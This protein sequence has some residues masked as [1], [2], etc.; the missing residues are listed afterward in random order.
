MHAEDV[1]GVESHALAQRRGVLLRICNVL[2]CEVS[3]IV[4][5]LVDQVCWLHDEDLFELF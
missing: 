3:D 2:V 5:L 1:L 4:E